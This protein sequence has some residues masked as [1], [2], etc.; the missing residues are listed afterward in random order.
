MMQ[1]SDDEKAFYILETAVNR[2]QDS[3]QKTKY[4]QPFLMLLNDA[5]EIEIFENE[6]KESTQNYQLLEDMLRNR[7]QENANIDVIALVVDTQIP[8]N[9]AGEVPNGIRIHLEEKSQM[10]KKLAARYLYIPYELCRVGEGEMFVKLHTP[11]PVGFPA[12][13]LI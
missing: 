10:H 2:A 11:I 4:F 3:M 13:Y 9:F 1:R 12:E 5:G 6:H 8:Q 7:L